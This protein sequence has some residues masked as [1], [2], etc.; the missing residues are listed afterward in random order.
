MTWLIKIEMKTMV[1]TKNKLIEI[2]IIITLANILGKILGFIKDILMS[3]YYGASGETDA[4]FL[5]MSL[6][7]LI[8]GV[9]TSG[10][11]SVIIPQYKR[12]MCNSGREQAD[13]LFSNII[14]SFIVISLI[15]SFVIF[16]FPDVLVSLFAPGFVGIQRTNSVHF[17]RIFSFL[18]FFHILYCYF[19]SY[20][21]IYQRI[22]ARAILAFSTNL[23][24]VLSLLI[25]HDPHMYVLSAAYIFGS[26]I[27]AILPIISSYQLGYRHDFSFIKHDP[28]M[29]QFYRLFIPIMGVAFL[30][31]LNMLV[32]KFLASNMSIGSIS[33]LNYAAK[34]PSIFDSMLVVGLGIVVL[35]SLS[36]SKA[37]GNKQEFVDHA[38]KIIKITIILLLPVS[39]FF[40]TLAPEIIEVIY[41]RGKF[42][43]G[44]VDLVSAVLVGYAPLVLFRPLNATFAKILHSIENTKTPFYIN[45][46]CVIINVMLSILLSYILELQGIAIAT[47]LSAAIGGVIFL[48]VIYKNVG[49]N[50]NIFSVIDFIKI[51]SCSLIIFTTI[52]ILKKL[53]L[54]LYLNLSLS[55]LTGSIVYIL[56]LFILLPN[57]I[58]N[59]II[60]F[61]K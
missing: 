51:V 15:F 20:N 24:V 17:L 32:D 49:W 43:S 58:K 16:L 8:L 44:S 4:F 54:Y 48:G 13:M 55:I 6:P 52:F 12:I 40:L 14:N 36:D 57:D 30:S 33:A 23:I 27:C 37:R 31:D 53:N 9:F 5:A 42:D 39:I 41:K 11:D 21:T 18:G 26:M 1:I 3:Y 25:Y 59:I 45:L 47:S 10:T 46:F 2:G 35:S 61:K 29:C 22:R 28:E 38:T 56:S 7:F 34:L 60:Y 50:L 19:C